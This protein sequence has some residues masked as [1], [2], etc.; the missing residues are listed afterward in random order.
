[1]LFL[2]SETTNDYSFVGSSSYSTND[3]NT[4]YIAYQMEHN[5]PNVTITQN[6]QTLP[7]HRGL[8]ETT[9]QHAIKYSAYVLT[10]LCQELSTL[11]ECT[12][13]VKLVC[14]P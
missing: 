9:K 11:L 6:R 14:F 13:S 10:L 2:F 4:V 7:S 1:M 8:G 5:V 12:Q 3:L